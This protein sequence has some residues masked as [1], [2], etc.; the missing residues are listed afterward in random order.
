MWTDLVVSPSSPKQGWVLFLSLA[1]QS[2]LNLVF[3]L[4]FYANINQIKMDDQRIT[5]QKIATFI[6]KM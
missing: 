1:F 5:N 2:V 3:I 4:G 6:D